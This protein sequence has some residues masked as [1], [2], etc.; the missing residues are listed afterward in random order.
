MQTEAPPQ[1]PTTP[2]LLDTR[3]A[4]AVLGCTPNT[5]QTWRCT[6]AVRVPFV[7]IGRLV[8][9]RRHDLHAFIEKQLVAE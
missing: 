6:R 3:Q 8:K 7:K 5:L 9:Y 4:A 2:E 1:A